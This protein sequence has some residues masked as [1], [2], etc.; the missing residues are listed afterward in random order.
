MK[1]Q[2]KYSCSCAVC[3][4]KRNAIE[5]EL[6]A[7]CDAYYEELQSNT[8]TIYQPRYV[9]SGGTIPPP[10]GPGP[11]PC[12]VELDINGAVVGHPGYPQH[13]APHN[14]RP[15]NANAKVVRGG[16]GQLQAQRTKFPVNGRGNPPPESEFDDADDGPNVDPDADLGDDE[17]EEED[18]DGEDYEE[19]DEE[20]EEEDP[21]PDPDD[22]EL[23]PNPNSPVHP[24]VNDVGIG[25]GRGTP[26]RPGTTSQ[27]GVRGGAGGGRGR[28]CGAES[29]LNGTE[30][31][32]N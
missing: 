10:P 24:G 3:G 23:G 2:Q 21:N 20:D 26:I 13:V 6:E 28:G 18:D 15:N 11:F 17:Y 27:L 16:K 31:R 29:P 4:R 25:R 32:K 5:G 1:E 12:S 19:E 30:N 14:H 9:S 22:E 8:L 7:L